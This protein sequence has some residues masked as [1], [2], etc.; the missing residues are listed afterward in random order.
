MSRSRRRGRDSGGALSSLEQAAADIYKADLPPEI[1]QLD[2]Q[3]RPARPIGILEIHP[4]RTQ[5][6]RTVPTVVRQLWDSRPDTVAD[7]FQNWLYEIERM[8][9][10]DFDLE[11]YLKQEHLPD[12]VEGNDEEGDRDT[13][14]LQEYQ[15]IP[16]LKMLIDLADLAI[17]IRKTGLTNP[18]TVVRMDRMFRLETGERRWLAYH[19]LNI[20][21][22]D[23]DW[24]RIPAH[25]VD[26]VSVWRQAS[27]NNARADLNAIGR[28]RQLAILL[29]DLLAERGYEFYTFD[30]ILESGGSERAYYA[31]VADGNEFRVPRGEGERLLN[32]MGL[33]NPTQIRQ[34]RQL[35]R[36]PDQVWQD[37]DDKNLT[38]G[39]VRRWLYRNTS[40]GMEDDDA[41]TSDN[42]P[43][44]E[45]VNKRRRTRIWEYAN[46]FEELSDEERQQALD[47]INEDE[48]WL[49]E[50]RQA[51]KRRLS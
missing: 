7:L 4:D 21:F 27:E 29:M 44:V 40:Y 46:R 17:S 19:L 41:S 3:R 6:R 45:R 39:E 16:L 50:L 2:S 23:E 38:E 26:E 9:W 48:R 30:E 25:L 36:L 51:I 42:N 35:L 49:D 12:G 24:E 22:P 5:P 18:I 33:K 32:A 28:A 11:T 8:G 34:Y 20:Y 14:H 13:Q 43:F 31:Q 37:A 15:R 1:A 47:A 10:L